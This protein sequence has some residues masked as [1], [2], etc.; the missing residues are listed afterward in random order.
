MVVL[1]QLFD[2]LWH[3]RRVEELGVGL[4]V[5]KPADVADA[6]ARVA[7]DPEFASRARV[8][9]DA[10]AS[11]DGGGALVDAVESVV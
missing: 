10:M 9:A 4:M 5:R 2:Q 1:P 7:G 3:G 6:V 11:E 8:L